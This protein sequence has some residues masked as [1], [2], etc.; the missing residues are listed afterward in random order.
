MV[1]SA[2][3][4]FCRGEKEAFTVV[5]EKF[6]KPLS[7]YAYKIVHRHDLAEDVMMDALMELV[8]KKRRF[9]SIEHLTAFLYRVVR[10][11]SID[12]VRKRKRLVPLEEAKELYLTYEEVKGRESSEKYKSAMANLPQAY[13]EALVLS[14]EEGLSAEEIAFV[15]KKSKKQVYNLLF[16]AKNAFQKFYGEIR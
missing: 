11:K 16:R 14:F 8:V 12:I 4:K 10:N 15:L 5:T 13:R 2:Y 9:T 7:L 6:A 1:L 3:E